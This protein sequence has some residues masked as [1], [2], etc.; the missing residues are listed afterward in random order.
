MKKC[1][2]LPHNLKEL[3]GQTHTLNFKVD[4]KLLL[5]FD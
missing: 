5:Y 2:Q 1:L 3:A 4:K